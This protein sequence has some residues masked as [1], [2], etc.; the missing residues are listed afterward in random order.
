MMLRIFRLP[1]GMG[2][3]QQMGQAVRCR[4]RQVEVGCRRHLEAMV[5][6]FVQVLL[7]H[8]RGPRQKI[9]QIVVPR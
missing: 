8:Q 4:L 1:Q 2:I 7:G 3:S 9:R 6:R 5:F